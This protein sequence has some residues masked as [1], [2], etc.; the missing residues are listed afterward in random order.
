MQTETATPANVHPGVRRWRR[1]YAA[2]GAAIVNLAIWT[3]AVP[4][5][6]VD[7]QATSGPGST[8]LEPVPLA[9]VIIMSLLSSLAGWA[10]LAAFERFT[11]RACSIWTIIALLVLLISYG[12]PLLG[13]GLSTGSRI[14]LALMHTA[15]AA[16]LIPVLRSTSPTR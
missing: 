12:G 16:V 3:L 2:V 13:A 9:A 15:V 10:L 1:L 4:I 11:D 14:T 7:L 6:G 8:E 5:A